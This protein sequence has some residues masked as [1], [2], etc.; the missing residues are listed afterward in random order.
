MFSQPPCIANLA[1]PIF[2][3]NIQDVINNKED[4][5][6]YFFASGN[7]ND[8]FQE[9]LD[10]VDSNVYLNDDAAVCHKSDLNPMANFF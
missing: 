2:Q 4:L 3:N 9:I 7:L 5:Q 10:L 6:K 1:D 8:S